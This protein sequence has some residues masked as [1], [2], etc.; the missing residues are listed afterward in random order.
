MTPSSRA[1]RQLASQKTAC[2]SCADYCAK[3]ADPIAI[4]EMW[5]TGFDAPKVSQAVARI[6]S[7]GS[8]PTRKLL[9]CIAFHLFSF[10]KTIDSNTRSPHNGH[11]P[12]LS[13]LLDQLRDVRLADDASGR[14]IYDATKTLMTMRNVVDYLLSMHATAM[15][16][17]GVA[18]PGGK[19]RVLLMDM[20]ASPAT[21]SRWL[22]VGEALGRLDR[23]PGYVECGVFSGE[24]TSAI[25]SGL[26]HI[27]KR[28]PERLSVDERAVHESALIAQAMSGAK[29]REI[30]DAAR[31]RAN[32]HSQERGG[33]PA[34]EDRT[35]N[36][37]SI[38][39]NSDGRTEVRGD[40]DLIIAEKLT[41]AIDSL[42]AERPEPDGSPDSRSSG[43]RRTEALEQIL[44]L[45]ATIDTPFVTAPTTT[46]ALL[47]HADTPDPA[48]LPWVGPVTDLTARIL[49]CDTS[50]TEVVIDGETVPLEMG[51]S[52]RLFPPHLR[53]AIV[54][55]D[56]CCVKCG[57]PASWSHVHHLRHWIDG[58]T[59]DLDNGCLLCP[60]CH[61]QIHASDW[62]VVMGHDRHPWLI[63]P[64]GVDPRRTPLPAYNRRTLRLDDVAA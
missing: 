49:A 8:P 59:T 11:M 17:L 38:T 36:S 19:T 64:V 44:D 53:K 28:S 52:K 63:P 9:L 20:G 54:I 16:R 23:L 48:R 7:G 30:A 21:A 5:T 51:R 46:L 18:G 60:S 29:P 34:A 15:D 41:T 25:V 45:A 22:Q 57:G 56:E 12:L 50:L 62:E 1:T 24:H 43:Q 14:E 3:N 47:V 31:S 42:S 26:T 35:I 61:A 33:I 37:L 39:Q 55:R 40:L 27:E 4:V 10:P 13:G 58:G 6:G 32:E 2:R